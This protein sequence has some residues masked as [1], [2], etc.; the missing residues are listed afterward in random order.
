MTK[1]EKIILLKDMYAIVNKQFSMLIK[2]YPDLRTEAILDEEQL[3]LRAQ[4][5]F[6]DD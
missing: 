2:H 4:M 5:R 1:K 6:L 3:S